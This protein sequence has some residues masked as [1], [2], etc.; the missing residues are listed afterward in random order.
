[1]RICVPTETDE[2]LKAKINAHFGS[3]AFFT[4][5]DSD[6]ESL[7]VISNSNQHHMHGMCQPMSALD[8][9][10]IDIVICG[11]MGARAVMKLNDSG[12]KAY[13]AIAGTVAD[14][15]KRCKA[16]SLEEITAES[17]CD[18]SDCRQ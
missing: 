15:I 16:G 12:I 10:K 14:V 6:K 17:A 18:H 13:K 8:N 4:I 5:Y 9:K 1:M 3:A 11:G 2:G 7:E